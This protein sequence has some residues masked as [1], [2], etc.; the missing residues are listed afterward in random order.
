MIAVIL[1]IL[2]FYI[3]DF[4]NHYKFNR[5]LKSYVAESVAPKIKGVKEFSLSGPKLK[6]LNLTFGEDFDQLSLEDKYIFLKPIMNDYESKRSWLIS[7]YNLYGKKTTIDEIVLPNIMINTNKGTYEYGSTNSLTEPN[8]DLHLESELDGTDEKNRQELEYKEKNI[9][10]LPPYNGMLESDI[11]K[12]SWGSP[13]SIEYSKNYDQMRPDRRYKWYKW[14]TKDSNGRI[15]EIKSLVVEQ[16]S[17]LG[18]PAMSKY[19]QQ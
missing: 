12:S 4:I 16:G 6:N 1:I 13:T 18:D 15:T 19:Y 11:S 3:G 10:S 5:D 9:G 17:V 2:V 7:K 14:I 8:G